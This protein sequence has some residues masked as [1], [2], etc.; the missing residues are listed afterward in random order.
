MVDLSPGQ[1]RSPVRRKRYQR[2]PFHPISPDKFRQVRQLVGLT[3]KEAACLLH[4]TARTVALWESGKSGIPYAAFKLLKILVGYE[5]PGAAWKGWTIRGDTLWSPEERPYRAGFLSNNWLTFAMA[6]SWHK[7][8]QAK[9]A[10][11]SD[12]ATRPPARAGLSAGSEAPPPLPRL[13]LVG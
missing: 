6:E 9:A 8:S 3:Q 7:A 5:L 10:A 4:V 11:R 12:K 1:D 13:R 2:K